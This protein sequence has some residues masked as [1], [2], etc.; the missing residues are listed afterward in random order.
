MDFQLTHTYPG[1]TLDVSFSIEKG[2]LAIL[3]PSG[4]G[5]TTILNLIAGL[6]PQTG[7]RITGLPDHASS[8]RIGYLFQD[9]ALF[10][11]MTVAANVACG[12][13]PRARKK[14]P[15]IRNILERLRISELADRYPGQLSAGQKQRAAMARALVYEPQ[16]LLLDEPFHALNPELKLELWTEL[17]ALMQSSSGVA[18]LVTHDPYEA[19]FLSDQILLLER[20]RAV[21]YGETWCTPLQKP[22][23]LYADSAATSLPKP[24]PVIQAAEQAMLSCGNGN[25]GGHEAALSASRIVYQCRQAVATLFSA[26]SPEQVV[27]TSN[28]TEALNLLLKGSLS[29]GDHVITTA[30]EHNSVLRPLYELEDA[31]II[32]LTIV[33]CEPDG[34]LSLSRLEQAVLPQTKALICTHASNVT[35]VKNDIHAIG[36]LCLA[37]HIRFYLDASQTAGVFPIRMDDDCIDAI[38]FTGHKSLLGPQ[39][40][41]GLCLS[42]TLK[43]R[44]LKT[45]GSGISSFSREHP[46]ALPAALEAGTLNTPG[47]AGLTAGI[48]FLK[49]VGLTRIREREQ[50]LCISFYEKIR[51]IPG[52]TIYGDF[53]NK[54]RAPIVSLN[55]GDWDSAAV[56]DEL[57][58]RFRISTRSGAHCAPLM[59]L[60]FHTQEQGMVRFSFS[61]QN[62]EAEL[63]AIAA[64]LR[65]LAEE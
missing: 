15:R 47:L 26:P 2:C 64:A 18:V 37:H 36:A 42:R 49:E 55:L 61:Y 52:I 25:R 6:L 24:L 7:C 40:T 22:A 30:M 9:D 60:H 21:L 56:S 14:D 62:T 4:S 31:G 16:I 57:E 10:P 54:D 44:P 17:K 53:Q 63:D 48:A 65:T 39:G 32:S 11:N 51:R 29:W 35:G 1:F 38:A 58:Q 46:S 34:T 59:H 41:G 13:G 27:F 3:G 8:C 33:P 20:G 5:K 12:L 45:G 50:Q 43:L 28:A 23:F 19:Q